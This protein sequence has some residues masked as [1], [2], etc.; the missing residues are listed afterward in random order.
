MKKKKL[1]AAFA[2]IMALC[3]L[4]TQAV[5]FTAFADSDNAPSIVV[6]SAAAKA[7]DTVDVTITMSNN[8]GL[9]S[10]NL[11]VNYDA[12][13]LTLKE[14]KDGGLL[15]G[16]THSDNYVTSPYGLCWVNDTAPENFTVNGVLATLTFEVSA[17]AVSGTSTI[18]LEQDILNFDMDNV[19]FDLVNGDIQIEGKHIHAT[20]L[21]SAKESTCTE[22][23]NNEYYYCAGCEKYFK[24]AEATVETTKEAEALPLKDHQGGEA[25]CTKKAVCDVCG[26]EYGE[27]ADH[28]YVENATDDFLK[29][30]ATCTSKAVYKKSCSVCGQASETETFEYG[31]LADHSYDTTTWKSDK[32]GH[33]HECTACGD[34]IDVTE[35]TSSGAATED[36]AEV[37][38]ECG[39]V[40]TPALGHTHK[41]TL[42][43]EV[44]ATCTKEG[45]KAYY[46]CEGC[47][48]WFED[49]TASVE[50][51]DHS[52]VVIPMTEHNFTDW[53]ITKEAT[54]TE[55]GEKTREC[56]VCG[57]AETEEYTLKAPVKVTVD[58]LPEK[59]F[60]KAISESWFAVDGEGNRYF[61]YE[62]SGISDEELIKDYMINKNMKGAQITVYFDDGSSSTVTVE[63][64][65]YQG[66]ID[67][68]P[69]LVDELNDVWVNV[70]DIGNFK[71]EVV[72]ADSDVKTVFTANNTA[73][74][75]EVQPTTVAPASEQPTKGVSTPGEVVPSGNGTV[76]TGNGN[77]AIIIAAILML[78][79][80]AVY[81]FD[82]FRK[83][84]KN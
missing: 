35:H 83:S 23:G 63:S 44:P 32:T 26:N 16:V 69:L 17:E 8:P 72:V 49:G 50:I 10:A 24:D 73:D 80:A 4:M 48:K 51:T 20:E 18:S 79:A 53:E 71:V 7:G 58:K 60:D 61:D 46:V 27:Y 54:K 9:V 6:S 3:L 65:M 28:Q 45:S 2:M 37:C 84:R 74:Q 76:Q 33:W 81:M 66:N 31:E 82:C 13:V 77:I 25:T 30:P 43:E 15:T 14:V 1:S 5:S 64:E 57:K 68:R 12:D 39:Y 29:T 56:L 11:Y 41:L 52:S 40:I 78:C 59:V 47:G 21:I 22:N 62:K 38:T 34:K 36:D 70:Y 55:P 42:V 19:V 67:W 75:P